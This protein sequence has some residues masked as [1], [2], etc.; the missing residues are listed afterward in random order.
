MGMIRAVSC[1]N[2]VLQY[3][4]TKIKRGQKHVGKSRLRRDLRARP[5]SLDVTL[6]AV[7]DIEGVGMSC[8][9]GCRMVVALAHGRAGPM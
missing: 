3:G 6:G 7:G 2:I 5:K 9:G 4:L 8:Q 1:M